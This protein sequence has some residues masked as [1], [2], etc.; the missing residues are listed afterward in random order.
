MLDF[1]QKIIDH[2]PGAIGI[3]DLNSVYLGGN[4]LLAA[5]MG[6]DNCHDIIGA[7]DHDINSSMVA[8]ADNFITQDKK[9]LAN[10]ITQ[11]LDMGI[12]PDG[13]FRAAVSTKK[14]LTDD[15]ESI[16]GTIFYRVDL[17]YSQLSKIKETIDIKTRPR[18][19]H[20]GT[21]DINIHF[22][23]REQEVIYYLLRGYTAKETGH[24]IYLSPKTIEYHIAQL[25]NK[26][27]CNSKS[28][29]IEKLIDLGLLYMIP[30]AII[31]S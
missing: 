30:S 28:S 16:I 15:N 27:H 26:C 3:K 2:F 11:H 8:L 31:N 18:Y 25:K 10:D 19:Y 12:Y 14:K 20:I 17:H 24:K 7:T 22:S 6:Y 23:E 1:N 9:A 21:P 4:D 29:L 13:Q 5:Y